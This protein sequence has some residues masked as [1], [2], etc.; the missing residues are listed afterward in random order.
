MT[1][2]YTTTEK[3]LQP[4][5]TL[6]FDAIRQSGCSEEV[7]ST[8]PSQIALAPNGMF[9]VTMSG[10]IGGTTAATAVQIQTMANGVAI[11]EM[12]AI[13]VPAAVGDLN[14]VSRET[15]VSTNR[16]RCFST[17]SETLAV[18]NTG[19]TPVVVGAGFSLKVSRA[20]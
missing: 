8:A 11:P 5:Q 2:L 15:A 6:V 10:N 14:A 16:N 9:N 12:L 1:V 17:G 13:S 19:T 20:G 3:T 18:T 4:G 7:N